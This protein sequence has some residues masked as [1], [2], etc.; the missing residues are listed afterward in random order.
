MKR[1]FV[2]FLLCLFALASTAC[3]PS[4]SSAQTLCISELQSAG[5]TEDWIELYNYGTEPVSLQGWYLS[6]DPTSPGN[7]PLPAVTLQ[8]AER[9]VVSTGDADCP[10]QFRLSSK[11]E[12]VVLTNPTGAAVQT[13]TVPASVPGISYGCVETDSFPP[14]QFVWYAV[15]TPGTSNE[16][17]MMLG[18]NA[19]STVHGVR[20][21]EYVLRNR[22]TL[23]DE[24]GDYGDWVELY[25]TSDTAID[26]AGW[27]LTD[28]ETNTARWQFP[29]NTVLPAHSFLVVFCDKKDKVTAT[30]ELHTNFCLSSSDRFIGLYTA[31]GTFCSGVTCESADTDVAFGCNESGTVMRCRYAT[32]GYANAPEIQEVGA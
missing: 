4:S 21:N 17:G 5:G 32:P 22:T 15:P 28:D 13:V 10:L 24:E 12:T 16:A 9:L 26:L 27:S 25:N 11:G 31:N 30:G 2:L 1:C 14:T 19:T 29:E 8:P 20:I 18:S 7:S 3:S 6:D 23:Y